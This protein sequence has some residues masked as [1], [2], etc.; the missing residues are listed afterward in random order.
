[1]QISLKG[2]KTMK[3]EEEIEAIKAL[4][5]MTEPGT[6]GDAYDW[7]T[8]VI[9][10]DWEVEFQLSDQNSGATF[11]PNKEVSLFGGKCRIKKVEIS[12]ISVT[13]EVKG[14]A[15]LDYDSVPPDA[16]ETE[17]DTPGVSLLLKDGS[18]VEFSGGSRGISWKTMIVTKNFSQIIDPT[19]IVSLTFAGT[20]LTF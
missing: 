1:M 19:Q 6:P 13:I 20:T 10:G 12:P 8:V 9:D 17:D 16:L 14:D 18:Q 11:R 2:F 4:P 5:P 3:S 15:I 7:E